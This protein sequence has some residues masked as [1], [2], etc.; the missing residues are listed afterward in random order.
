MKT[1]AAQFGIHRATVR[2]ILLRQRVPLRV[3]GLSKVQV[4]EAER[5]Y[6]EGWSVARL[7]ERFH[8]N[9]TT[10]WRALLEREIPMRE[11]W[12]RT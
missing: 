9:G 6:A 8:T 4:D 2:Q 5:L 11:P 3:R 12:E 1:L 7:G 10:V